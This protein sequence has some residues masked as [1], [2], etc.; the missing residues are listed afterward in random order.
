MK[1]NGVQTDEPEMT[2]ALAIRVRVKMT[3]EQEFQKVVF[4]SNSKNVIEKIKD[5]KGKCS[6]LL[7]DL[8][9]C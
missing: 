7:G 3:I 2:K 8:T 6:C 5:M 4:E 1:R 9:N